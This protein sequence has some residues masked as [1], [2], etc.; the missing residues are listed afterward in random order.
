MTETIQPALRRPHSALRIA[1]YVIM[2]VAVILEAALIAQY[3]SDPPLCNEALDQRYVKCITL[4]ELDQQLR[5]MVLG[6]FC[7]WLIAAIAWLLGRC[8]P[9]LVSAL[10]PAALFGAVAMLTNEWWRHAAVSDLQ[11]GELTRVYWTVMASGVASL[12][13]PATGAWMAGLSARLRRSID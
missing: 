4:Q 1:A 7:G 12:C 2:T 5:R 6:A 3:W 9:P 10:L 11:I 8:A 13:A